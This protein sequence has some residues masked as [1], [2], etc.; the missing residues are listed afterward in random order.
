MDL[1]MFLLFLERLKVGCDLA[2]CAVLIRPEG[3]VKN[4]SVLAAGGQKYLS[5]LCTQCERTQ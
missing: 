4:H 5:L 2:I 1:R 3:L